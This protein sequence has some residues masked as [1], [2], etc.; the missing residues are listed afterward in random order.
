MARVPLYVLRGPRAPASK[1]TR[2]PRAAPALPPPR[3]RTPFHE[4]RSACTQFQAHPHF[5]C[6]CGACRQLCS[7]STARQPLRAVL[8]EQS[9]MGDAA[10]AAGG[11]GEAVAGLAPAPEA[12]PEAGAG[13]GPEA[14]RDGGGALRRPFA[15]RQFPMHF[16]GVCDFVLIAGKRRSGRSTFAKRLVHALCVSGLALDGSDDREAVDCVLAVSPLSPR[17]NRYAGG[18]QELEVWW[19]ARK[20]GS[21]PRGAAIVLL[22]NVESLAN[23]ESDASFLEDLLA[24]HA[25]RGVVVVATSSAAECCGMKPTWAALLASSMQLPADRANTTGTLDI[26]AADAVDALKICGNYG[27]LWYGPRHSPGLS[28][29]MGCAELHT[30]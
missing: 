27:A 22:D 20:L 28:Y 29:S 4:A 24:N 21:R 26:G 10:T 23:S 1:V 16:L 17:D 13:A 18:L 8:G 19:A 5:K 3:T 6:C 15:P 30:W 2:T 11:P 7:P 12:E 25:A 14:G 9:Y